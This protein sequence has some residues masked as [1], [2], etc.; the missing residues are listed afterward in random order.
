V[1]SAYKDC[2][3]GDPC[4]TDACDA[5]THL[6]KHVAA[7]LP[8]DDGNPCT[9][10]GCYDGEPKHLPVGS[11]TPCNALGKCAGGL[12]DHC[13]SDA[14]CG[15]STACLVYRCE[16]GACVKE[17][18]PKDL[19]IGTQVE[20]DCREL[21]C[22]GEGGVMTVADLGDPPAD[23]GNPCTDETCDGW[24]PVH[25]QVVPETPCGGGKYCDAVGKCVECVI[26]GHCD[27]ASGGYCFSGSCHGCK[28]KIQNGDE[29][30]VDCGGERCL[31]C[32][33]TACSADATCA[34]G[35]CVD[36]V[37]CD[38]ACVATCT[39]CNAQGMCL[40]LPLYAT[41]VGCSGPNACNGNGQCKTMNG[42]PCAI[43]LQCLSN[44]CLSGKC[45]P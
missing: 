26:D 37:C 22:D 6:C 10:A 11:G 4:T 34:S 18:A 42:Y 1:C 36:A 19:V 3:D 43:N 24:T 2:D 32:N 13:T 40:P 14:Q 31:P 41:D 15:K 35:Y 5:L 17:V 27:P 25:R 7:G 38:Q 12:C 44:N 9:F 39:G 8:P 21:R 45:M 29:V 16:D 28:D 23:D 20:R 30:G 33:G